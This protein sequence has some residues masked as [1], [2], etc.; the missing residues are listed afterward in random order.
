MHNKYM[1]SY[2]AESALT[3]YTIVK[4]GV[5]GGVVPATAATDA[6]LGA[7]DQLDIAQGQTTDVAV[8]GES[9]VKAGGTIAVGDPLTCNAS[10][11]AIKATP[12]AGSNVRLI[13]FAT[14][15]GVSGDIITYLGLPQFMQG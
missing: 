7:I 1:K 11:Q 8:M 15:A 5:S 3:A 14:Q 13:G 4:P 6:L 12:A 2:P 10:S 9:F